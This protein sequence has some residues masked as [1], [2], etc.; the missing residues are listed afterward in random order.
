MTHPVFAPEAAE[1]LAAAYP[2]Q[3]QRLTHALAGHPLLAP[4]A[5]IALAKRLPSD[6]IKCLRGNVPVAAQGDTE[7]NGLSAEETIRDIAANDSW[8][9]I[10][11]ADRDPGY[12]ALLD[13]LLGELAAVVV[14]VT[15]RMLG[16][17]AFIFVSSPH[18]VTPFHFDGEHNILLQ[19]AGEKVMTVFSPSDAELAPAEAH[20]R[21]HLVGRYT[22]DWRQDFAARGVAHR[23][24]PGDA[25]YVPVKAPHWVKNGA[26]PSISLSITWRSR[27]SR[28]EQQAHEF[29]ALLRRVGLDPAMPRRFPHANPA[30]AL[31]GRLVGKARS[32]VTR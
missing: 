1:S 21:F 17:E 27:W 11:S 13:T 6:C 20:E 23:L 26:S 8:M 4:E 2:E 25:L 12:A 15:G 32:V 7:A 31:G 19:I 30:K 16:R 9:V 22:L 5:L 18:A 28:A 24:V 29:N 14:P 3:P 10:K